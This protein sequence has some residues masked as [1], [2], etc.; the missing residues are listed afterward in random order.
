MR[1]ERISI[2]AV[3]ALVGVLVFGG[4]ALAGKPGTG[5]IRDATLTG[6]Q[7]VPPGHPEAGGEARFIFYPN[8]HKICYTMQVSGIARPTSAHLHEAPAGETG[9]V[10]LGLTPPRDGASEHECIRGLGKRFIKKIGGNPTGYYVDV[11]DAEYEGGA[12]RGQLQPGG[13]R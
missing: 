13:P 1:R 4:T 7:V 12:L 8:R 3:V 2:A 6:S 11:H 5:A 9:P 10:K